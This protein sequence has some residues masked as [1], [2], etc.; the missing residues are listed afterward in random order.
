MRAS[1]CAIVV[2]PKVDP[3][4]MPTAKRSAMSGTSEYTAP[5]CHTL[6]M[7][8]LAAKEAERTGL[9]SRGVFPV[10]LPTG[11]GGKVGLTKVPA[12]ESMSL[13]RDTNSFLGHL[14]DVLGPLQ[15]QRK[16]RRPRKEIK[17]Q[18]PF[19]DA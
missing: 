2:D 16:S 15:Q 14:D 7:N 13:F 12:G 5:G 19:D 8:A 1:L 11:N 10:Q 9:R 4:V 18:W 17:G 6:N 3:K